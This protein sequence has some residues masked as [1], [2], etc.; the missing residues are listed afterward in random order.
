[1]Y[2]DWKDPVTRVGVS[3]AILL[4]VITFVVSV[5]G[6]DIPVPASQTLEQYHAEKA[7]RDAEE[8]KPMPENNSGVKLFTDPLTGCHYLTRSQG[9]ITPRYDAEGNHYGCTHAVAP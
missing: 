2:P 4:L 3:L 8:I 1:M 5:S 9:A 6:C 7:V